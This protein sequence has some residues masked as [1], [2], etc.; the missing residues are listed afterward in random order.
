MEIWSPSQTKSLTQTFRDIAKF[1]LPKSF[2]KTTTRGSNL[3]LYKQVLFFLAVILRSIHLHTMLSIS[4]FFFGLNEFILKTT[5]RKRR[6]M[7]ALFPLNQLTKKTFFFFLMLF[8]LLFLGFL[9]TKIF[10][11][12]LMF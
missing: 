11:P 10:L 3:T 5:Q 1:S 4:F 7:M 2:R 12:L 6:L 8:F 9:R